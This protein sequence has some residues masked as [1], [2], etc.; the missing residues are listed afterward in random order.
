MMSRGRRERNVKAE[1][2]S[3]E[4]VFNVNAVLSNKEL[5]PWITEV[6]E[7]EANSSFDADEKTDLIVYIDSS[8]FITHLDFVDEFRIQ[9]KSSWDAADGLGQHGFELCGL[10]SKR[11]CELK[12][13]LLI[14]QQ[15]QDSIVATFLVQVMNHMGILEDED[16]VRRFMSFQS[17]EAQRIFYGYLAKGIVD[18]DWQEVLDYVRGKRGQVKFL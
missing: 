11:W 3:E 7:T 8:D 12:L 10:S 9:V 18:R 6:E 4:S 13:I 16:K 2:R 14:G 17:V 15:D 5:F 1:A